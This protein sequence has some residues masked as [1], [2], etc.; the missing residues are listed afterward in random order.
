MGEQKSIYYGLACYAIGL[1]LFAFANQGWM[2]FVFLIP[3]S[4]GGVCGPALQSVITKTI[5]S[6]EQGELQG[7]LTSLAS[8]TSIV[9]PPIMTHLFYYFTQ[10]EAPFKFAGAPFFFASILMTISAIIVYFIFQQKK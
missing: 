1:L 6:N 9:G 3:Y 10:D 4:L 5:P 8:A 2:M 7:A